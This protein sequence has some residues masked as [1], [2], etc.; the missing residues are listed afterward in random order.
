MSLSRHKVGK[1]AY[2]KY[3]MKIRFNQTLMIANPNSHLTMISKSRN[4]QWLF[5]C[6]KMMTTMMKTANKKLPRNM[7]ISEEAEE[8]QWSW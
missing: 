8:N 4:S 2:S 3:M 6:W 7:M 1:S 5:L